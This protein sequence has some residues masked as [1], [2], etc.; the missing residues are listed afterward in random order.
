MADDLLRAKVLQE[1]AQ[2]LMHE[3]EEEHHHAHVEEKGGEVRG[4]SMLCQLKNR[5]DH[6]IRHCY[7]YSPTAVLHAIVR[8]EYSCYETSFLCVF[9]HSVCVC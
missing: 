6:R 5:T 3:Q 9:F 2:A 1:K 7:D 4:K 8:G